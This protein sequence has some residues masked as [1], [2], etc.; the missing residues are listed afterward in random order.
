MVYVIKRKVGNFN[1]F[2]FFPGHPNNYDHYRWAGLV[3]NATLF[4]DFDLG[5]RAHAKISEIDAELIRYFKK[6]KKQDE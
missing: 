3:E 4:T 6:D 2:A 5:C 1:Y